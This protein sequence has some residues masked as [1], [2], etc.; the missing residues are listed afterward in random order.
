MEALVFGKLCLSRKDVY[1]GT[2][3]SRFRALDVYTPDP[4]ASLHVGYDI[5]VF[6]FDPDGIIHLIFLPG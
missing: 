3:F 1:S 5:I 6:I 4:E 2:C